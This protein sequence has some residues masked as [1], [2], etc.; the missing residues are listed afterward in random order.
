M[1]DAK[2]AVD[3]I[4]GKE[5]WAIRP[6]ILVIRLLSSS[7]HLVDYF[8]VP[9]NVVE[10]AHVLSKYGFCMLQYF[11]SGLGEELVDALLI[12]VLFVSLCLV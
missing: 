6:I 11:L 3:G 5:D 12:F 10:V 8:N 9:R 4:K 1:L 2:E 7:F